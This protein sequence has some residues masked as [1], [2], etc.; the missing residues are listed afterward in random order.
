MP[1]ICCIL[2]GGALA[3]CLGPGARPYEAPSPDASLTRDA[4]D[5]S[6][7]AAAPPDARHEPP[8]DAAPLVWT[9]EF[10]NYTATVGETAFPIGYV[11]AI[12]VALPAMTV[13]GLGAILIGPPNTSPEQLE[14][15]LYPVGGSLLAEDTAGL[16]ELAFGTQIVAVPPRTIAAGTYWIAITGPA[17]VEIESRGFGDTE[18]LVQAAEGL[19]K[20]LP[21]RPNTAGCG[22]VDLFV[23]GTPPAT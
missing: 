20:S 1:R 16:T 9:E 2:I 11:D 22:G 3:G 21:T 18:C 17:G 7:D 4:S 8:P 13:T 15:G 14:L 23:V 10:G 19:P 12:Q 5:H 6:N